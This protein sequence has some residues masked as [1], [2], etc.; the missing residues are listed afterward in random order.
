[1]EELLL[2]YLE[3]TSQ[4]EKEGG[5]EENG[6]LFGQVL[7]LQDSILKKFGLPPASKYAKILWH[8]GKKEDI[9]F[10]IKKLK[11][12]AKDYL[13]S[14]PKPPLIIL[15]EAIV[16]KAEPDDILPEIGII[17]H[18]YTLFIYNHVLLPKKCDVSIIW[19]EFKKTLEEDLLGKIYILGTKNDPKSDPIY[20]QIKKYQLTFIDDYLKFVKE[21]TTRSDEGYDPDYFL[22]TD[23]LLNTIVFDDETSPSIFC[24]KLRQPDEPQ[25]A[26]FATF[27]ELGQILLSAG[28]S[29]KIILEKISQILKQEIVERPTVID[30]NT[31]LGSP[32][33]LHDVFIEVYK[34]QIQNRDGKWIEDDDNGLIVNKVIHR[35]DIELSSGSFYRE[36]FSE[37]LTLL[38][39]SYTYYLRIKKQGLPETECRNRAGLE[40]EFLL[41]QAY[42]LYKID[43]PP[44]EIDK[45]V[46]K[47]FVFSKL[48][49]QIKEEDYYVILKGFWEKWNSSS[50]EILGDG[51]FKN[52]VYQYLDK[53]DREDPIPQSIVDAVIDLILEYLESIGQWG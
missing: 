39:D 23:L 27:N 12:A 4:L 34:H 30:V 5:P 29:G 40:N 48:I 32:L 13:L 41:Y 52:A 53:L 49:Y 16:S 36:K 31:E 6:E 42:L 22:V 26:L 38:S 15:L 1:M 37:C 17:T 45:A 47:E 19:E 50:F 46:L 51:D 9:D 35:K 18:D 20:S 44:D 8:L 7:F 14:S 11:R 33:L 3:L 2:Q 43:N 25:T 21:N 24:G 10:I 28:N